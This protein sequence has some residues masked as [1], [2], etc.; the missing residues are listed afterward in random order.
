MTGFSEALAPA[1]HFLGQPGIERLEVSEV[2]YIHLLFD[3]HALVLSE[4]L[5]TESFHPGELALGALDAA[6][7][8]EIKLLFPD[9]F[10]IGASIDALYP[11]SRPTLKRHQV[12]VLSH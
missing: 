1:V 5:W 6:Q 2:S 9:L 11:Q 7:R 3:R 12:A 8:E 10:E 4:G